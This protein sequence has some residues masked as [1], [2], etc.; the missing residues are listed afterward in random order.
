MSLAPYISQGFIYLYLLQRAVI[1][2]EYIASKDILI[3][4]MELEGTWLESHIVDRTATRPAGS[5]ENRQ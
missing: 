1:V 2:S 5:E 3:M 4:N